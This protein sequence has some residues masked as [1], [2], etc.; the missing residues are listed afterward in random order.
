MNVHH[1]VNKDGYWFGGFFK[2]AGVDK[3]SL[4]Q[5]PIE[6]NYI[7]H[8]NP[9]ENLDP[10]AGLTIIPP[11][12]VK[13]VK[14]FSSESRKVTLE[15][16]GIANSK[17]TV[18]WYTKQRNGEFKKAGQGLKYNANIR[19]KGG[20]KNVIYFVSVKLKDGTEG[21]KIPVTIIIDSP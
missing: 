13:G 1:I 18:I 17:G 3:N 9:N 2:Y 8:Y 10:N 19:V 11:K 6:S 21:G 15:A 16:K 7:A 20:M 5:A 4:S 12:P 14:G